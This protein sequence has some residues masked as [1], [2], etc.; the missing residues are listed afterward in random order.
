MIPPDTAVDPFWLWSAT[1]VI[2]ESNGGRS[3]DPWIDAREARRERWDR[4][5][6]RTADSLR[7][8][9]ERATETALPYRRSGEITFG[10][11][12][13]QEEFEDRAYQHA[14]LD[15]D[16]SI[17]ANRRVK[18]LV[19]GHL[20]GDDEHHRRLRAQYRRSAPPTETVPFGD[21]RRWV[22]YQ[23]GEIHREDGGLTF[24][25]AG[26]PRESTERLPWSDLVSP[27]QWLLVELELIR[28]PPFARYR[29]AEQD[30]WGSFSDLFRYHTGAFSVGP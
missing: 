2:R 14:R 16:A 25:P 7:S 11:P 1:T 3:M 24:E 4:S 20:W 18:L 23:N 26:E 13:V 8:V 21:Y 27:V 28:N 22:R 6:P 9:V 12:H 10:P 30:R 19:K 29:L 5:V 15:F 17:E